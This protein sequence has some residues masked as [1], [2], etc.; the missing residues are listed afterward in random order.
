MRPR[1]RRASAL[2]KFKIHQDN[3]LRLAETDPTQLTA[4][5]PFTGPGDPIFYP[6]GEERGRT[7]PPDHR[8][9]GGRFHR[10][11]CC[12]SGF[13]TPEFRFRNS[14][15]MEGKM[16]RF[17]VSWFSACV[18]VLAVALGH[19]DAIGPREDREA[20]HTPRED[21]A[22]RSRTNSWA[23]QHRIQ[24]EISSGVPQVKARI[25]VERGGVISE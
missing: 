16:V 14:E 6:E 12:E 8:H 18:N 25:R 15:K 11:R 5:S 13:M 17:I 19:N 9:E 23:G 22:F 4:S 2:A 24:G 10:S 7:E 1:A 3:L 20:R 21:D